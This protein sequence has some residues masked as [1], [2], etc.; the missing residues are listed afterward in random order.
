[1]KCRAGWSHR[2]S[3]EA[4]Q[5]APL[6]LFW[7]SILNRGKFCSLGLWNILLQVWI[8]LPSQRWDHIHVLETHHSALE[9]NSCDSKW[10]LKH[11]FLET[12]FTNIVDISYVLTMQRKL[13]T[14]QNWVALEWTAV[15]QLERDWDCK[16][17]RKHTLVRNLLHKI[18]IKFINFQITNL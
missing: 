12:S 13:T 3:N 2:I 7:S 18:S 16:W 5:S 1:M 8:L 11:C 17:S 6:H 9:S 14:F 10:V 15:I 4:G